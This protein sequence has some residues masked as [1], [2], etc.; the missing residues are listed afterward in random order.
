[1]MN[2][3]K[4]V[5]IFLEFIEFVPCS[6]QSYRSAFA[7]ARITYGSSV[8]C[9]QRSTRSRREILVC[10]CCTCSIQERIAP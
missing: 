3:Q 7:E 6:E 10:R 2:S 5:D 4:A 8:K 9:S 1:M